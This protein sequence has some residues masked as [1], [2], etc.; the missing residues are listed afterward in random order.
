MSEGVSPSPPGDASGVFSQY[1]QFG[2]WVDGYGPRPLDAGLRILCAERGHTGID[3]GCLGRNRDRHGRWFRA[4]PRSAGFLRRH[5]PRDASGDGLGRLR[6]VT[7][8]AR[9]RLRPRYGAACIQG[10]KSERGLT[11][12]MP[13]S[14]EF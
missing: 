13:L 6:R 9:F 3:V 8:A 2:R 14:I 10:V 7:R 1:A 4:R 12:I 5:L 11:L